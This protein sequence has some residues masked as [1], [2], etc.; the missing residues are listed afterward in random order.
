MTVL[1]ITMYYVGHV[2]DTDALDIAEGDE[3]CY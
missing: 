3:K 2:E 1:A